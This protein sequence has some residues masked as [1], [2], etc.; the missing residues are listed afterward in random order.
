M[1]ARV[2][3][4][5]RLQYNRNH[6]QQ[7]VRQG[8]VNPSSMMINLPEKNGPVAQLVR[9]SDFADEQ[10]HLMGRR[11]GNF[12]VVTSQIRGTLPGNADGNPEPSP[13]FREGVET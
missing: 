13:R 6:L 11:R 4:V 8:M 12:A 5:V 2:A 10:Y 9:A 3:G 7:V 1:T